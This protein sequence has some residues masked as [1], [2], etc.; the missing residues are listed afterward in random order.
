MDVLFKISLKLGSKEKTIF[1]GIPKDQTD[2]NSMYKLRYETYLKHQYIEENNSGIEKDEYDDGRSV[3]FIA[4]I[5]DR[6]IGT[7]R[8]IKDDFLPTE[9]D[10]FKFEEPEAIKNMPRDNRAEVGRLIVDKYSEKVFLPRHVVLL[11]L[12]AA[13]SK[14]ALTND[15]RGGYSFIKDSLK[16]KLEK[17]KFPF[18]LIDNFE[19]IYE[20]GVLKKY[21]N[22]TNDTVWPVY[23]VTTEVNGYLKV[24]FGKKLLFK[25]VSEDYYF[26]RNSIIYKLFVK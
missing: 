22:D 6:V 17:I 1:F 5:D 20:E 23:Y 16:L 9:K 7:A 12:I 26:L 3:Y 19:K 10:C 21:F 8:L 11:G 15:L 25:K 14:Y 18:H 13:F 24:I 4:K 2:L